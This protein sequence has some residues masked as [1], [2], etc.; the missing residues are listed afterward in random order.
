MLEHCDKIAGISIAK[1]IGGPEELPMACIRSSLPFAFKRC[2]VIYFILCGAYALTLYSRI[3]SPDGG[4]GVV[5][6]GLTAL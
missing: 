5:F 6:L 3:L 4:G 2:N 1:H